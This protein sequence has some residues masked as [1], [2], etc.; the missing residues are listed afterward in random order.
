MV[1]FRAAVTWTYTGFWCVLGLRIGCKSLAGILC[2][3]PAQA[4]TMRLA[5]G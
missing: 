3:R 5:V 2:N 4:C 1:P